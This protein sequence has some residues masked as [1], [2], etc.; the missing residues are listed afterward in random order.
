MTMG[1]SSNSALFQTS[2][3]QKAKL[4]SIAAKME[5]NQV[6]IAFINEAVELAC[7]K[8][9]IFD[10]LEMWDEAESWEERNEIVADIQEEIDDDKNKPTVP[11]ER[12]YP[13]FAELEDISTNIMSFKK[14]LKD[15]IDRDH[16]GINQAALK[17]GMEQSS[18][19]RFLNS[20][21]MPR[22]TTLFK[23]ARALNL[24]ESEIA[25]DWLR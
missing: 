15:I 8:E 3:E 10:L 16:G 19:S 24:P 14:G 22:R 13:G 4:Y 6:D 12:R 1:I 11:T 23:I 9:G 17:I 5:K 2:F 20:A 7:L 21:S 18:L 25:F